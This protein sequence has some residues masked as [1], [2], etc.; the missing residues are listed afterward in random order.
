[1]E[2]IKFSPEMDAEL[3]ALKRQK[4]QEIKAAQEVFL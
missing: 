3:K 4:Q 2:N 1:L